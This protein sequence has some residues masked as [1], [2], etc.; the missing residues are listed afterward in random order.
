MLSVRMFHEAT[1]FDG[2]PRAMETGAGGESGGASPALRA[3][4]DRR[5]VA[6]ADGVLHD[7]GEGA[8]GPFPLPLDDVGGVLCDEHQADEWG[9]V[10]R[11]ELVPRVVEVDG[12]LGAMHRPLKCAKWKSLARSFADLSKFKYKRTAGSPAIAAGAVGSV[13][14][15]PTPLRLASN[16]RA[17]AMAAEVSPE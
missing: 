8:I 17:Y 4:R 13:Q 10:Q 5:V 1:V 3:N 6:G 15:P 11:D 16:W 14:A 2:R 12:G 9:V 7:G